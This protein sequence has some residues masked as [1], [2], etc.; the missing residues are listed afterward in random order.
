L[1]PT[2]LCQRQPDFGDCF[3][4]FASDKGAWAHIPRDDASN[5]HY[6]T[7]ADPQD[8]SAGRGDHSVGTDGDILFDNYV[9]RPERMSQYRRS[10][11][12]PSAILDFYALRILIFQ[13]DFVSNENILPDSDA[14]KTVQERA[15][16][17]RPWRNP[18]Q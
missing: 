4:E 7:L 15:N 8:P 9:P 16:C 11:A 17:S 13:I 18:G 5:P 10:N 3:A 6:G 1:N 12:D 2:S 14:P